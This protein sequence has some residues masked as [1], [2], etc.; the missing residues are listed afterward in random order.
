MDRRQFVAS[1]AALPF[2][3]QRPRSNPPLRVASMDWALAETMIALGHDPIAIVA[4][5]DWNRYVVEPPLPRGVAD[6]GLHP[7]I[8][9]ELLAT[10]APDL[11][12]TS[13]FVQDLEPVLQRIAPVQRISIFEKSA[14]PLA[15]PR[16][17]TRVLGDSLGRTDAARSLLATADQ[18]FDGYRQRVRALHPLP[19]LLVNFIDARHVRVY[20]GAGLYQNVLDRIGITNAWTRETNYWG[21][22]TV[23]IETLATD[24]DLRLIAFEPVPPDAQSTLARSPLWSHLPFVRA[25]HVSV[26]PSVLMFGAIPSALRFARLLVGHLERLSR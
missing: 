2:L 23:G 26:L 16:E 20:G 1:V 4:A 15:Q 10:L 21:Y 14:V 25:G 22:S 9:F 3:Q 5:A 7:E 24:T 17:V 6:L 18:A 8:N 19:V 13:P 12:L 11:I